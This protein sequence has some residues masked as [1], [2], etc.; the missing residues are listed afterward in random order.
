MPESGEKFSQ[1]TIVSSLGVGG[2]GEVYLAEDSSLGRPAALKFLAPEF[3]L[4]GDHINR[5][6]REARAASA[7]NHPN[8]CTIYEIN[9]GEH[10]YIAMEY[11]EGETLADMVR[12]RR[13]NVRQTLHIA[14]QI[15]AGLAEAHDKGIVHR[16]IK[17]A[18]II[19]SSRGQV[20]ILD[21]GL[22][23]RFERDGETAAD[24]FLTKAGM[25]LGTAS[26]MSPE[27]ARGQE[28]NAASD[29]WSFGVCI[30]EML[31]G[32]QPFAGETST[33]TLAAVLTR[34]PEPPSVRFPEIPEQ[35]DNFVLRALRRNRTERY[36][37]ASEMLTELQ[38][39]RRQVDFESETGPRTLRDDSSNEENTHIFESA[40]TE[41]VER[42]L[43]GADLVDP[44][45]RSNNLSRNFGAIIGRA[46]EKAAVISLLSDPGTPLVTLTGIGGTGKTRLAQA[47]GLELLPEFAD[48]VFFIELSGVRRPDLV[49]ATIASPLGI[50]DTGGR[51]VIELLKDHLRD[52]QMLLVID[53]FEQVIEAAP[54]LAELA[55]SAGRLKILV[56]SRVVLRL[57][58]ERELTVPPL[59]P[60]EGD[61]RSL[62][63]FRSNEAVALFVERAISARPDFELTEQNAKTVGKICLRLEGLPLAIELAAARI[64]ILNPEGI[65]SRLEQ[66]L[67]FL[68]GG[69][70]DLPQR[71]QTI[72]N[73]VDWSYELLSPE[74]QTMFLAL[75]VF[76]GGF[77][78]EAAEAIA[79]Q[80]YETSVLDLVSSLLDKSLVLRREQ[81]GGEPRFRMLDVVRDYAEAKLESLGQLDERRRR[82]AEFFSRLA[83]SAEPF[84]QAAQSAEWLDGLEF[85]HDNIRAA[86]QWSLP[87]EPQLAVRMAVAL[88]NF[89]LLH[90]H[91]N[92]GY[93]WLKAARDI[94]SDSDAA[95]RFKLMNGLGL[96]SRFRGD[97][98]TAREAYEQGL[99]EGREAGD[100]QGIAISSRGLGLVAMQ[101]KDYAASGEYFMSGLAISRE[102]NDKFGIAISLSFLG[103]LSR[104]EKD[105]TAAR[106]LFEESL[107]LF[108]ELGNKSAASDAL[109]N[110]GAADFGVGDFPAARGHFAEALATASELGNK[111][112]ISYSLDGFAALAV[113]AGEYRT[114]ARLAAATEAIRESIGYNIEP[115]ERAFREAYIMKL[116][117][118]LG[119]T[120]F[121]AAYREGSDL[122]VENAVA[123][124]LASPN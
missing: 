109:N 1:Y 89:W 57:S 114:A 124:A 15:A 69:P 101:Q 53:N 82:H 35:L 2:M 26:Y 55:G 97:F 58:V 72:Q 79:D 36:A 50:K 118:A 123:D 19:I 39:V 34:D 8:I 32:S 31:T 102:L 99:I 25:I 87:H 16:D 17:P 93:Q 18:N 37:D 14:V 7:L 13:R 48:G 42:K 54:Q 73:M 33:D 122:D 24:Q 44:E 111:M 112:T 41:V 106:P 104:T 100:K 84:L 62:S 117:A 64:R 11:I 90:S 21:F 67:Q 68:T 20:K 95:L 38:A 61:L 105:H 121:Q 110:L 43:T 108:R 113:E 92:E 60:P 91:L 6:I 80:H 4:H 52:K 88:R 94:S 3:A 119:S 75:S 86:M 66:R 27:Q 81:H 116:E 65:L 77:R 76:A 103:D 29:V 74:E 63:D 96:A 40:T 85:E 83:E 71:Q 115:A 23:K 51:P 9:D 59:S 98:E 22:A 30:Y 46:K 10:P 47:V 78:L 12:R 45:K 28:V 56:T 70:R 107:D 5:F 120:A 49:A